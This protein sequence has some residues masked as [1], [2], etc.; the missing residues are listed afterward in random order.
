MHEHTLVTTALLSF[1]HSMHFE[2]I[3]SVQTKRFP[4]MYYFRNLEQQWSRSLYSQECF[5]LSASL[6]PLL[7]KV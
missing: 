7:I 4:Q 3:H 5:Q 1:S 2:Q 6:F